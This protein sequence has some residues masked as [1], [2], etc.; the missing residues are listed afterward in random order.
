LKK[1]PE[2]LIDNKNDH[3]DDDDMYDGSGRGPREA[4]RLVVPTPKLL[5]CP[6][7]K[8]D[9]I[10]HRAY[11]ARKLEQV[12]CVIQHLLRADTRGLL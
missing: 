10:K 9:P 12:R 4:K 2:D 3:D 11:F 1:R 5:A 7:W 6:F 8:L